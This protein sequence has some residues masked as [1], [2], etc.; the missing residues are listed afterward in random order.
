MST[1]A[2]PGYEG[3][4]YS[5]GDST[6]FNDEPA[7]VDGTTATISDSALSIFDWRED[8]TVEDGGVVVDPTTYEVKYL[9]GQIEFDTAPAGAV[10][11]SGNYLPRLELAGVFDAN[12]ELSSED[13]DSTD[14]SDSY[15]QSIS[16]MGSA[17]GDFSTI[18]V[19]EVEDFVQ[20]LE[21]RE[22]KVLEHEIS[23]TGYKFRAVIFLESVNYTQEASD[24]VEINFSYQSK[25]PASLTG[26]QASHVIYK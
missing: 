12:F 20:D 14:F 8:I 24:R 13:I 3:S 2:T 22:K 1:R 9:S 11:I 15:L 25:S 21:N 7:T 17:S 23:S 6:G 18:A 19:G 4:L 10:T 5:T 26:G 16:G